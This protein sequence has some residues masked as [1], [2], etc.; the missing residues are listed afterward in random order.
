MKT[1]T[2]RSIFD[3]HINGSALTSLNR[4]S[5]S[6][7]TPDEFLRPVPFRNDLRNLL[8]AS[9]TRNQINTSNHNYS[10]ALLTD[11]ITGG[12]Y[13]FSYTYATADDFADSPGIKNTL[14]ST[15]MTMGAIQSGTQHIK[16]RVCTFQHTPYVIMS[17]L[18]SSNY[19]FELFYNNGRIVVRKYFG[20]KSRYAEYPLNVNANEYHVYSFT[21]TNTR[22][23]FYCDGEF[24][25]SCL[26][27][28]AIQRLYIYGDFNSNATPSYQYWVVYKVLQD[29]D[30]IKKVAY[31]LKKRDLYEAV[32]I[33]NGL[34]LYNRGD[35][36]EENSGGWT[37]I[38]KSH[39]NGTVCRFSQKS[40]DLNG[41]NAYS[42]SNL[43]WAHTSRLVN[44]TNYTKLYFLVS[45][46]LFRNEIP[47]STGVYGTKCGY[48]DTTNVTSSSAYIVYTVDTVAGIGG[49]TG[50]TIDDAVLICMDISNV[51]GNYCP[52]IVDGCGA[53]NGL[54]SKVYKVW[55]A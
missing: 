19:G 18:S 37:L 45:S 27:N 46:S 29:S 17:Y 44:F 33:E 50:Q 20:S 8:C 21:T 39:L 43:V 35:L 15:S 55:L 54:S 25:T 16:L 47:Y 12:V 53:E 6:F 23:E 2:N 4:G 30:T 7:V 26:T 41:Y 51:S 5:T 11:Y 32:P 14:Y 13:N 34:A 49:K 42:G 31:W 52:F 3:A 22:L 9:L 38:P 36:C 48:A 40:I 10:S 1:K 24:I 28:E